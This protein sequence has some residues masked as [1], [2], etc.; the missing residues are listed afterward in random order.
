MQ[1]VICENMVKA[2]MNMKN[3]SKKQVR[4]VLKN[5]ESTINKKFAGFLNFTLDD[6]LKLM[7]LFRCDI[8]SLLTEE[9]F[10]NLMEERRESEFYEKMSFARGM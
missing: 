8:E 10:E 7:K 2:Q 4:E 1:K 5:S 6:S 3:I 9:A